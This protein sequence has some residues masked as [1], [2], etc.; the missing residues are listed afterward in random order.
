[1]D[2]KITFLTMSE[3]GLVFSKTYIILRKL[4]L[5]P[6][7]HEHQCCPNFRSMCKWHIRAY[8]TP[9]FMSNSINFTHKP[10]LTEKWQARVANL[11]EY[12]Q[13]FGR[14]KRKG[15]GAVYF[16]RRFN[17]KRKGIR[18]RN[19]GTNYYINRIVNGIFSLK[20]IFLTKIYVK[21]TL[22][23][24]DWI[25]KSYVSEL[26]CV[27]LNFGTLLYRRGKSIWESSGE[28]VFNEISMVP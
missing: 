16:W 21:V 26:L 6:Q 17:V 10:H 15:Q 3:H 19:V 7:T 28:W 22:N 8:D 11:V 9:D 13:S 5:L 12:G 14:L 2:F 20:K 27:A 23:I 4:D 1:M 25:L 18:L 24:K